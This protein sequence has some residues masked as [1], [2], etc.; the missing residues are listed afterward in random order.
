M[1]TIPKVT[2]LWGLYSLRICPVPNSWHRKL[3]NKVRLYLRHL[4]EGGHFA[5]THTG[6]R[7]SSH[8]GQGS[9]GPRGQGSSRTQ[10]SHKS[11]PYTYRC[12][13]L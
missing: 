5:K 4:T 11:G 7:Y 10:T 9:L 8:Q 12:Q 3:V 6:S 13:Q 2:F 1:S